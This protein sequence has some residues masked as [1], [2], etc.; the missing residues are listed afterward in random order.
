MTTLQTL[1][2]CGVVFASGGILGVFFSPTGRL[3]RQQ[4]KELV[5]K[6]ETVELQNQNYRKEVEQHFTRTAELVNNMTS[7]YQAVFEHLRQG[8]SQLCLTGI[9]NTDTSWHLLQ[10]TNAS[11]FDDDDDDIED[12]DENENVH[13][14]NEPIFPKDYSPV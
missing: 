9:E 11:R 4:N 6:L 7:S 12:N 10:N 3:N 5:E 14:K 1:L 13:E 8:A 2:L